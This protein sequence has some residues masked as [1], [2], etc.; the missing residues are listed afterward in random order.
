MLV[1]VIL[2]NTLTG[3]NPFVY[4]GNNVSTCHRI[5]RSLYYAKPT[6]AINE[7]LRRHIVVRVFA[8]D[9]HLDTIKHQSQ[10]AMFVDLRYRKKFLLLIVVYSA[11]LSLISRPLP[12]GRTTG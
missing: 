7:I 3:L 6:E 12:I 10:I 1:V 8:S 2:Q 11:F 5:R 9:M 4:E